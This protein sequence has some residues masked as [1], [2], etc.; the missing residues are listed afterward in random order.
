MLKVYT[1]IN[2]KMAQYEAD[3]DD[4]HVAWNMVNRETGNTRKNIPVMVLVPVDETL[5]RFTK[6]LL[7]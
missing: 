7:A 2:G 6:P 3:T 5:N 1:R 4:I